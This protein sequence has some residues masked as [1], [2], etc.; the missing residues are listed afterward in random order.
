MLFIKRASIPGCLLVVSTLV[1]V[2]TWLL[3]PGETLSGMHPTTIAPLAPRPAER[4][5][6]ASII[7]RSPPD[8]VPEKQDPEDTPV[9]SSSRPWRVVFT[10][11][12]GPSP[13]YTKRLLRVLADHEVRAAFF[14]NGYWMDPKR[15]QYA[16]RSQQMLRLIHQAGHDVGNHTYNH[17]WLPRLTPEEQTREVMD[18]V[19]MVE[20]VISV[21]PRY[22]RPPYGTMTAHTRELLRQH[23]FRDIRWNAT[24]EDEQAAPETVAGKVMRWIRAH[25]GGIIMLH[26]S[27]EGTASATRLILR[28]LDRDNCLRLRTKRPTFQVVSLDSF[29]RP[30]AKSL[31]LIDKEK[32]E[33][34]RH[35]LRLRI[36]CK[37]R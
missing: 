17:V 3:A 8:A 12:D 32:A 35:L 7:T 25:Q 1:F 13:F 9:F 31:T 24:S 33:R 29:L 23:G 30:P 11:D 14:V 26:D 5:P 6:V 10:F 37:G 4:S 36:I 19:A 27:L 34:K 22:F 20:R 2:A 21:R 18:N 16:P 15:F 28:Q